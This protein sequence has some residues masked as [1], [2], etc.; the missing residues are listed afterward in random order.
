MDEAVGFLAAIDRETVRYFGHIP[1]LYYWMNNGIIFND[2]MLARGTISGS[3]LLTDGAW[4][5]VAAVLD[6]DGSP[7]LNEVKLYVDGTEEAVPVTSVAINTIYSWKV[8]IGVYGPTARYF[9]GLIDDVRI[10]DRPLSEA[11]IQALA[12]MGN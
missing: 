1:L 6:N 11:E 8:K 3:S 7:N 5:H 4:H 2:Y 10:Y 9:E 12:G